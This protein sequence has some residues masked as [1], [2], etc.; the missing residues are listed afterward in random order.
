MRWPQKETARDAGTTIG[1]YTMKTKP[2][3][4][5]LLLNILVVL[6]II[7]ITFVSSSVLRIILGLPLVLLFPG[8]A[9]AAALLPK[10]NAL[11]GIERIVLSLGLSIVV[12]V[13]IGL[14]LDYAPWG[15]RLYPIVIAL[16]IFI[17][18]TSIVAWYQ[19]RRLA[20][21]DKFTLFS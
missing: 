15:I 14:I 10:R 21:V 3:S 8:Y 18:A 16:S 9:L 13:I 19:R 4:E 6:F 17:L 20:E 12:V 1:E 11:K 5:L 2:I 7:A